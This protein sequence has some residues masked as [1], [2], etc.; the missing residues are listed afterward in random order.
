MPS[1]KG[2]YEHSVDNKGRVAFPAK[3]RKNVS[4][5]AEDRYTLL[6]GVDACLYL[7][8]QDEWKVVENKLDKIN[9]FSRKGR[10]VKRNILR[11]AED[12]TLDKQHRISLPQHLKEWSQIDGTAIFIGSGERIEIWAPEKLDEIDSMLDDDA[13]ADLFEEVMGDEPES[14]N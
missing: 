5:D 12:V 3:L 4:P 1:F 14:E 9:S 10:T 8:P 6:R 7:Y 11:Y 2:Q 13:Y